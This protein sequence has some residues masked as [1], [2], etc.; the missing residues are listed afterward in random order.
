MSKDLMKQEERYTL[1][2][3]FHNFGKDTAL[4]KANQFLIESNAVKK[5]LG[6]GDADRIFRGELAEIV[7]EGFLR[8]YIDEHPETFYVKSLCIYTDTNTLGTTEMD[9]CLFT[10]HK[11][12]VFECK[13]FYGEKTVTDECTIHCKTL[14]SPKNVFK[15]NEMHAKALTD[16]IKEYCLEKTSCVKLCLF[17]YSEKDT[18][19]KRTTENK[20]KMIILD[21]NNIEEL[22]TSIDSDNK[23]RWDVSSCYSKVKSLHSQSSEVFKEHLTRL[24]VT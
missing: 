22:L 12:Y 15:Q 14:K 3:L 13:S 24:G 7:L 9:L 6:A 8:K 1:L 2:Y 19:D 18:I 20:N 11:I 16:K 10:K 23:I 5:E 4:R 21:E 17:Q